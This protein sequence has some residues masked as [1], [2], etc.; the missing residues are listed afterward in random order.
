MAELKLWVL[1]PPA[2][3]ILGLL[4]QLPPETHIVTGNTGEAFATAPLPDVVFIGF[5]QGGLAEQMWDRVQH[6]KW[7]HSLAAGL[8]NVL[9]PALV[10]SPAPMTNSKGVFARSLGE[11]TIAAALYFA[12]DFR[13][14]MKSQE[15]GVWDPFDVEE[16]TGKTLGIVGYG[17]IGREA[18][19]RAVAM[20]MRVIALRR[21]PANSSGDALI[22]QSH[23]PDGIGE[24]LAAS[25]YVLVSAPNTA[26]TR[27]LI[28]EAQLRRMKKSAV[29]INVGRGPV[30]VESALIQALEQGWIRGAA[31]DVF[32]VEPLPAGHAFYRL[33]NVLLSPHCADHTPG[34]IEESMQFFVDNFLRFHR[35]EALMNL[36]D[37]QAGY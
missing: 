5:G 2:A 27:G 33:P 7:V 26:A 8:E 11:F 14:M 28:G 22:S 1:N 25:D 13:R 29:L 23:G 4:E 6:A 21:N 34:W 37:K 24:L 32:D 30:I 9:F 15:A 17:G 19:K 12:K 31:L 36:V 18:A 10:E 20:G 16:L 3:S 35:G